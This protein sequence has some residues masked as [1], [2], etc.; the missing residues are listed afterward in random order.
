M[1]VP[2]L[3]GQSSTVSGKTLNLAISNLTRI[4]SD[5]CSYSKKSNAMLFSRKSCSH[6]MENERGSRGRASF[7][8]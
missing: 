7:G 4:R 1:F 2:E 6:S 5:L 3:D 8:R